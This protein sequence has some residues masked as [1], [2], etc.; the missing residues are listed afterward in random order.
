MSAI[1]TRAGKGTP[2]TNAEVDAN[3]TNLNS[4][5]AEQSITISAGAGLTG[6]GDL[7]ANRTLG[8]DVSGVTAG[9]FGGNNSIPTLTIDAYGRVTLAGTVTPSGTWDISVSGSAAAVPF[10]GISS[11]PTTLSGYGITDAQATLVSGTNIKTVNGTSLLGSGDLTIDPGVTSFNTRTGAVTLSSGDV[12]DALGYTPYNSS[13]PNGY[14]TSSGSITGNAATATKLNSRGD[15]AATDVGTTRGE[16]GLNMY[17]VHNNG[18]PTTYGSLLHMRGGGAGQILIGWSGSDGAHADNYIRSKRD[19]DSGAW[20]PWALLITS[21]NIGSQTVATAG[22]IDSSVRN[23]SREWIEFPNHS[24]L[25][26]PLNG[27]HFYPNNGSYGSWKVDGSRNGWQGLEFQGQATLMMNDDTYGFHRNIGGGWRFY[28]QGGSGHFPGN[29][30]AYWSDRR[31]KEN[32]IPIGRESLE[33]LSHFTTF[34]FNWNNKVKD[35]GLP[36]EPGKEEIGL[37]AQDVQARLPD[38]VQVNKTANKLN[39]D[40]SQI[41]SDYLTINWDKITPILVGAV[42]IHDGDITELRAEMV[43]LRALLE[44]KGI[45]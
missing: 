45:A 18:Y 28:C 27:A 30:V 3:F 10:S 42:N 1:T 37:V 32:F 9:S 2:L 5:K 4:D 36:I 25:Y 29:V 34:R 23:Y 15:Y 44:S 17:N 11:K 24:A 16:S 20:S 19:N 26:S 31:L 12:T 13:N 38:A 7:S 35:M 41:E 39:E 33:I 21:A 22:R 8:L 43:A 40:G 14:I 6:G